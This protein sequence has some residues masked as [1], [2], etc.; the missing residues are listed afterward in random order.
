[1]NESNNIKN[2][3]AA[4]EQAPDNIPLLTH[5][6]SEYFKMGKPE[7]SQKYLEKA[8]Q[9]DPE[10]LNLKYE[11]ANVFHAQNK[12]NAAL[13]ILEE[14]V[15]KKPNAWQIHLLMT[16]VLFANEEYQQAY[17]SY[18]RA[19]SIDPSRQDQGLEDSLLKA[20]GVT[21][22]N[23]NQNYNKA[24][25]EY[26]EDDKF[27]SAEKPK[28]TFADVGG[29]AQVKKEISM[30]IIAPIKFPD[31]YQAFDKKAGGG[32]LL[33]GPPGC[34]KT[35]LAKATAG[36]VN[37][38]FISV[39]INDILDMWI[40]NSEK[41]LHNIF[42]QAR[43]MAPCVL[44]FDEVDALG[45]NRTDMKKSGAR[46]LINQFLAELDGDKYDNS[47][48]LIL[49]AT[50]SPW[51]MDPAFRRP[52]RFDRIIFIPPPDNEAREAIL[53]ILLK[54]KPTRDIKVN[55]ISAKTKDFSGADLKGIID[56]AVENKLEISMEKGEVQPIDTKDIIK[57]AAKRKSSVKEWFN[58]ARNYAL[59]ANDGGLYDDILQYLKMDL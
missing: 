41:N 6:A 45:A 19:V 40:G 17:Q 8:L 32:I 39:G 50:N 1:M 22:S 52:G 46:H 2:L 57:A 43:S 29:M 18:Q 33:Y 55:K 4:L 27:L 42:E 5:I 48:V 38:H 13:I 36:E 16:K 31:L 14:L 51:N 24:A 54:N 25:V 12:N 23:T 3:L 28:I 49:A 26:E 10:S 35:H 56:I 15:N 30:K 44:F 37:A 47:G 9:L 53:E 21:A 34:G 7:D 58:T 59:Y 11:L 20:L